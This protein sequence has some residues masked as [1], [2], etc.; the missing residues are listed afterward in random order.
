M[1]RDMTMS[2][3]PAVHLDTGEEPSRAGEK[4]RFW[5]GWVAAFGVFGISSGTAA[6]MVSFLTV[7]TVLH[8]SRGLSLLVSSMLIGCL[9]A[10][11]LAAHGMDRMAAVRRD[12]ER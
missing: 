11:L 7:C 12:G 3:G 8:E 10:L 6:L 9:G 5:L 1:E 4:R 2:A